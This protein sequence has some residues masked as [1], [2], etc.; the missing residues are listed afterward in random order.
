MVDVRDRDATGT[1]LLADCDMRRTCA[2]NRTAVHDDEDDA[3]AP[4]RLPWRKSSSRAFVFALV[5]LLAMAALLVATAER[6]GLMVRQFIQPV[7]WAMIGGY[8]ARGYEVVS[9]PAD[10][11]A[12]LLSLASDASIEQPHVSYGGP[13]EALEDPIIFGRSARIY[14]PPE[15]QAEVRNAFKPLLS[16]FCACELADRAIIG[17][18]GVRVYRRGASL[19]SHLDTP[20]KFVISATLN[21]RQAGNRSNWPLRMRALGGAAHEVLH[22]EGEAVLYEGSRMLHSRSSR[23]ED[24]YYVAAFVGFVPK[25]YPAGHG[26]F[27]RLFVSMVRSIS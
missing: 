22:A 17:G 9:I 7:Q 16:S 26:L 15:L 14:I 5:G 19:A 1:P 18:G 25:D 4:P 10:I 11:H 27:T 13:G 12:K 8:H 20:H 21:V 6:P 2:A 24:D 3:R 23:L